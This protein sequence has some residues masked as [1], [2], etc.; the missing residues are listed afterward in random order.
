MYTIYFSL[1]YCCKADAH[2][3]VYTRTVYFDDVLGCLFVSCLVGLFLQIIHFHRL[4][5]ML[6]VIKMCAFTVVRLTLRCFVSSCTML[7]CT[8]FHDCLFNM[9]R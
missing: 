7:G 4:T 8:A 9:P 6:T 1:M 3:L 2:N 5:E